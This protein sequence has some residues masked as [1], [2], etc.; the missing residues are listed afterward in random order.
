LVVLLEPYQDRHNTT[1]KNSSIA[2]KERKKND[3]TGR[4]ASGKT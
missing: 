3:A 1:G 4:T 2:K